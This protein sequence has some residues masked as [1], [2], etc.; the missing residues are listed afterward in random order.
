MGLGTRV[1]QC[2]ACALAV[3]SGTSSK[4][5]IAQDPSLL[6]LFHARGP[7]RAPDGCTLSGH[8]YF[9]ACTRDV[10]ISFI[11]I[12]EDHWLIYNRRNGCLLY[13]LQ[14][15]K[16]CD[17]GVQTRQATCVDVFGESLIDRDCRSKDMQMLIRQC[18]SFKCPWWTEGDWSSVSRTFLN[19][20]YLISVCLSFCLSVCLSLSLALAL[21]LSLSLSVSV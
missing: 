12:G 14:C 5:N 1:D 11:L 6:W 20:H 9:G 2:G 13:N 18:N 21:S 8:R 19:V 4:I 15:S 16:S 7:V 10:P 3:A 17:K